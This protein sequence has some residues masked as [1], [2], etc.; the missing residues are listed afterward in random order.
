MSLRGR[1]LYELLW[2]NKFLTLDDHRTAEKAF[3]IESRGPGYIR[4]PACLLAKRVVRVRRC[5]CHHQRTIKAGRETYKI[6]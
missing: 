5:D 1:P 2:R 6:R 3:G 4:C